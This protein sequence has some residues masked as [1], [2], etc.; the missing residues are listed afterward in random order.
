MD[1]SF[2]MQ[3][4]N[5]DRSVDSFATAGGILKNLLVF[6]EV[7]Q[8]FPVLLVVDGFYSGVIKILDGLDELFWV[9]PNAYHHCKSAP[10]VECL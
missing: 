4:N 1:A 7:D 8:S 9:W 6:V 3:G 5:D 2:V 10:V